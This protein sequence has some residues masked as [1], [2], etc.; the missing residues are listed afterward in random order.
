MLAS[1]VFITYYFS[2]KLF[3][4]PRNMRRYRKQV[5]WF[6]TRCVSTIIF[7]SSE[8]N[9]FQPENSSPGFL[10]SFF[11][12]VT[13]LQCRLFYHLQHVQSKK[14]KVS[15][16]IKISSLYTCGVV[17]FSNISLFPFLFKLCQA[18]SHQLYEDQSLA[19]CGLTFTSSIVNY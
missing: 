7:L 18:L 10:S 14:D 4:R 5:R 3:F 8:I 17:V 6:E 16:W 2:C 19:F 9:Y 11:V 12:P 15:E 1:S 13:Y